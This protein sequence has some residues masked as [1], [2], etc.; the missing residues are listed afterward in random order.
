[1]RPGGYSAVSL[2]GLTA[3]KV[4]IS[5]IVSN[6]NTNKYHFVEFTGYLSAAKWPTL[7]R[8]FQF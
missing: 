7:T 5:V 4:A 8:Y 6:F 2:V 1:M 3:R